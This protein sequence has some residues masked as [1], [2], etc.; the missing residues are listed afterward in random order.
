MDQLRKLFAGLSLFQQISIFVVAALVVAGLLTFSHMRR[1]SD[2]HP[3]YSGMAPEDAATVVQKLKEAAVEYR[4]LEDGATVAVPSAKLAESRLTLAA[5]GLPKSGRIGFELFDKNNFGA[6]EFVEHINYQRALEGELERSIMSLA[7]VEQARVHLTLP[8]ES[9]FIDRQEPAKASVMVK[10]KPGAQIAPNNVI[11]V[12]NLVASA[13][14]G[15]SPDAV[16]LVDM[17]GNLLSKPRRTAAADGSEITAESLEVRQQIEKTLVSKISAT[18]EPLLG[19]N[20]F[21][22]GASVDCDLTS[23]EQQEETLD[24]AKSVMLSSQKTEEGAEH[25]VAGGIPGTASNLPNP[26]NNAQNKTTTGVSRRTENITY[27]ASRTVRTTHIPQG[28]VKRMSLAVLVDQTVQWDGDGANRKKVLVP[29]APETLKTIRDLVAGVTGFDENRGDQLIVESL[30]FESSLNAVPP[31]LPKAVTAKPA[32]KEPPILEFYHKYSDLAAPAA[33]GL[34]F[35]MALGFGF[36]RMARKPKHKGGKLD[37]GKLE[38]PEGSL[39]PLPGLEGA[40]AHLSLSAQAQQ[41]AAV[42]QLSEGE[43][44]QM[45]ERIRGLAKRDPAATANVLRMW[46]QDRQT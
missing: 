29:P 40:A 8:K 20:R 17:D 5:A 46:L 24:P 4:L 31:P 23:G 33:I 28:L 38:L 1:E 25:P 2:F 41:L 36:F 30:P 12:T 27:Q 37:A 9:V 34:A 35:L 11:A 7:E 6:T 15:L 22:A 18:L 42:P 21:R 13:V 43:R 19:A 45:A 32:V 44:D 10:L 16:S 26:P 14:Q 3:L 39:P